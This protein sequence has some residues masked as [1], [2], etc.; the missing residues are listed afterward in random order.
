MNHKFSMNKDS[1][2]GKTR[3]RIGNIIIAAINEETKEVVVSDD[4]C[5]A[6]GFKLCVGKW[7]GDATP[8]KKIRT[9]KCTS[10]SSIIS[11]SMEETMTSTFTDR[12]FD[13]SPDTCGGDDD[14]VVLQRCPKCLCTIGDLGKLSDE[15]L[16]DNLKEE[17]GERSWS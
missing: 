9:L 6:M 11:S 8:Y 17:M 1:E 4:W 14:V 10:C 3:I 2:D 13:G 16:Y 15:E 7:F 5:R 12:H